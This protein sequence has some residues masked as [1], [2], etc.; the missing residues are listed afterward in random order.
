MSAKADLLALSQMEECE[1][2]SVGQGDHLSGTVPPW[3]EIILDMTR[4]NGTE[5]VHLTRHDAELVIEVL[6][7][8]LHPND[9]RQSPVT[10]L[11]EQLDEA[12]DYLMVDDP[13]AEDQARARAL[14]EAIAMISLPHSDPP[15]VAAV[16]EEAVARWEARQ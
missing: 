1:A 7:L 9:N 13:E 15:D 10:R 14:A 11:W 12:M 2:V 4:S 16:R 8:T 6:W 3:C 5:R